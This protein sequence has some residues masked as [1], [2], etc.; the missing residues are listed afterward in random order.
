VWLGDSGAGRGL[1]RDRLAADAR[2]AAIDQ[3]TIA[4]IEG[5]SLTA[6]AAGQPTQVADLS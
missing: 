1:D 3:W 2:A 4:V 6:R 5:P